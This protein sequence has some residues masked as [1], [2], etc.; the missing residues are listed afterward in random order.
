MSE[1]NPI[2]EKPIEEKEDNLDK[3]EKIKENYE[4]KL[5]DKDKE[6][7]ELKKQLADKNKEVD[8]T[9]NNLNNEVQGKLEQADEIKDLQATVDE[10]VR[11]RAETTVD[12][13]IQKGI[14]LPNKRETAVKLCLSDNDTFLEFNVNV[15]KG[16][17]QNYI[18][19]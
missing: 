2:D 6:I 10:L 7:Q 5:S 11:E 3:F 18:F 14:I 1:E 8:D 4:T 12:N 13:Y 19:R 17:I 16:I 9:I 15:F